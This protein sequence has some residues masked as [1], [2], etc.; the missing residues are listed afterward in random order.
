MN[1]LQEAFQELFHI[2]LEMHTEQVPRRWTR[3]CVSYS[4]AATVKI[5]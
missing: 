5:P 2:G 3:T 4:V 1:Q